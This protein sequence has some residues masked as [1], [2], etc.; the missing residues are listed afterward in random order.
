MQSSAADVSTLKKDGFVTKKVNSLFQVG[1]YFWKSKLS[2]DVIDYGNRMW[3][4]G[5][6]RQKMTIK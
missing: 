3:D 4:S 6:I 2:N 1:L 5:V